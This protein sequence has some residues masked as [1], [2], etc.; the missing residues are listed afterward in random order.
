MSIETQD[1]ENQIENVSFLDTKTTFEIDP[2]ELS[3]DELVAYVYRLEQYIDDPL[4]ALERDGITPTQ[5]DLWGETEQFF[6]E[7]A[8]EGLRIIEQG[9]GSTYLS[10]ALARSII[11][12]PLGRYYDAEEVSPVDR[13]RYILGIPSGERDEKPP[14]LFDEKQL[15]IIDQY[16]VEAGQRQEIIAD[17]FIER[18]KDPYD[19]QIKR[20]RDNVYAHLKQLNTEGY[21]DYG[22]AQYDAELLGSIVRGDIYSASYRIMHL[23]Y[24]L[25]SEE[26]EK[27][28]APYRFMMHAYGSVRSDV[29][30]ATFHDD[31]INRRKVE[32]KD[33]IANNLQ[34]S[35]VLLAPSTIG[36]FEES[37]RLVASYDISQADP[38]QPDSVREISV[39]D[40]VSIVFSHYTVDEQKKAFELFYQTG[41]SLAA[42]YSIERGM[43][44]KRLNDYTIQ[45]QILIVQLLNRAS[46]E[47]IE[48]I[49]ELPTDVLVL[50]AESLEFGDDYA[51]S[52]LTI[53]EHAS[54]E[55]STEIF[56][57]INNFRES[58]KKIA[59]WYESYD[60]EFAKDIELAMNERLSDAL[61]AMET[62]VRDGN[63]EVDTSPSRHSD[64]YEGDGRFVMK[65]H[66]V[67]E[68]IEIINS[69]EKSLHLISEIITASDVEVHNATKENGQFNIYRFSSEELG[70][71]LMYIRPEGAKGYDR[72]VEYGNRAGVEASMSF[73]VNPTNPHDLDIYK[74]PQG[75]SIRF[76]RE[77]RMTDE[78]PFAEDRDPTRQDGSISL[79]ISSLMGDGRH[80]PVKIGRFIA[81][82]NILRAA[83][84]GGEESLHHNNNHFD[85]SRYGT[86]G[87]FARLA[88]YTAHMAEAMIAIQQSG[89]H[90]SP[91][92]SIPAGNKL[93]S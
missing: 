56:E 1:Q 22:T 2:D 42:R 37:G 48:S 50:I 51:D 25:D 80:M 9:E 64:D 5:Q 85:Q 55:Q 4:M 27:M 68:G 59:R 11:E 79:D 15:T 14:L 90:S 72:Q 86:A 10:R 54:P 38:N 46:Q 35:A 77:G 33:I 28:I 52:I 17:Y 29:E 12:S 53:V 74:D 23:A 82:G 69:L 88:V 18:A 60:P 47:Q 8:I 36:F 19:F 44:G 30:D 13:M 67:G 75:V 45:E 76:D 39:E 7:R 71:V 73:I 84:T 16:L 93:T 89:S 61:T 26:E 31:F 65:L 49:A 34:Y 32:Y 57:T 70:D 91:Y 62:L 41:C 58:S 78:S 63:L 24:A 92:P 81:A 66:S 20:H 83:K 87:G 6:A 21:I 40:L 3:R 43:G